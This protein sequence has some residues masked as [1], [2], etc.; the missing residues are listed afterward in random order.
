MGQ[1]TGFAAVVVLFVL[2]LTSGAICGEAEAGELESVVRKILE[3]ENH[4]ERRRLRRDF[5]KARGNL[6]ADEARR[7]V[8]AVVQSMTV[9]ESG[10]VAYLEL[11]QN[12]G[13]SDLFWQTAL[14]V[15]KSGSG[16]ALGDAA[17]P[18]NNY[19]NRC[20]K[21]HEADCGVLADGIRAR[22]EEDETPSRALLA[23][24]LLMLQP[25]EA[26]RY[27][28]EG[29][30]TRRWSEAERCGMVPLV[31]HSSGISKDGQLALLRSEMAASETIEYRR[32]L[33]EYADRMVGEGEADRMFDARPFAASS[34]ENVEEKYRGM[35]QSE[36]RRVKV[37]V[38]F[39]DT[40]TRE[41]ISWLRERL[42]LDLHW[43]SAVDRLLMG[44]ARATVSVRE[45]GA[46]QVLAQALFPAGLAPKSAGGHIEIVEGSIPD[47][48]T[49]QQKEQIRKAMDGACTVEFRQTPVSEALHFLSRMSRIPIVVDAK[50]PASALNQSVTLKLDQV[51]AKTALERILRPAGLKWRYMH[52]AVQ[53]YR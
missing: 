43:K 36:L 2:C 22:L 30:R 19:L 44:G 6:G 49:A 50:A 14:D 20:R 33:R 27:L 12:L 24:I 35:S 48:T 13:R 37:S 7:A 11:A 32:R 16:G 42:G 40:P 25:K 18:L 34:L 8:E 10:K 5:D 4:T 23:G 28:L 9:D 15:V 38:S 52:G 1:R 45:M 26:G 41:V 53:V 3:A 51:S 39:V 31:F 47:T 46:F 17:V 29:F 21:Y